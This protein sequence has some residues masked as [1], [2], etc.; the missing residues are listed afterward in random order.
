MWSPFSSKQFS[1]NWITFF[2]PWIELTSIFKFL[3]HSN[4]CAK[5][6]ECK[7]QPTQGWVVTEENYPEYSTRT[8]DFGLCFNSI[9]GFWSAVWFVPVFEKFNPLRSSS[10]TTAILTPGQTFASW[11]LRCC[12]SFGH[13]IQITE[14]TLHFL[15]CTNQPNQNNND[16][17]L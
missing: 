10:C 8:V 15:T 2:N 6:G 1:Q 4:F 13:K 11:V 12:R 5:L 3:E 14:H 16:S 7:I 17:R 9:T